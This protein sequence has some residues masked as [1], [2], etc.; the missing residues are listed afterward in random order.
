[1]IYHRF[2]SKSINFQFGRWGKCSSLCYFLWDQVSKY[3][4][5]QYFLIKVF[6]KKIRCSV[7][8]FEQMLDRRCFVDFAC[9]ANCFVNNGA[10]R[11]SRATWR[12]SLAN[13]LNKQT[14]TTII[15]NILFLRPM[16]ENIELPRR[17]ACA[18][19]WRHL[20]FMT[21]L[22]HAC[23][24]MVK[25][26][27]SKYR[28]GRRERASL[29]SR[30]LPYFI[31]CI[32]ARSWVTRASPR[33]EVTRRILLICEFGISVSSTNERKSLKMRNYCSLTV[34]RQDECFVNSAEQMKTKRHG[35]P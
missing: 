4:S 30:S 2:I 20:Q 28:T 10:S 19:T 23:K 24:R 14:I 31:G 3:V 7:N 11:Q 32:L 29:S 6:C 13:R 17:A 18:T 16:R 27:R 5:G 12:D 9:K 1:M 34:M 22:Y 35:V 21:L 8:V 26:R 25:L 15:K 33:N